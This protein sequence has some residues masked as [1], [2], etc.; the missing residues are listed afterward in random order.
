MYSPWEAQIT[1]NAASSQAGGGVKL[2]GGA[3]L[4]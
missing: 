4:K 3:T 2:G 1:I